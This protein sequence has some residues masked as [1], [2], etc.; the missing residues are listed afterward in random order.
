MPD[1]QTNRSELP[2]ILGIH[3]VC[4]LFRALPQQAAGPILQRV[5][6][7]AA[8]VRM[9]AGSACQPAI[10]HEISWPR[11]SMPAMRSL[12]W[13]I[14]G[15]AGC[16]SVANNKP[17]AGNDGATS[18]APG[19]IHWVRSLS[20]MEALGV[21][22]G[23]GGL[24]VAGAISAPANLGGQTLVPAGAFD[25]IVAGFD[26]ETADHVFSVR[27]GDVGSEF[28]FLHYED[29][30]GAPMVYGVSYGNVDLGLNAMAGGTPSSTAF[31]DGFVGR[32]GPAAP[33]WIARIVRTNGTGSMGEDK[34]L[35]SAPGPG[36]TIYAGGYLTETTTFSVTGG[37]T[38]TLTS[39]GGRDI[40]LARFNTFTGAVDLTKTYGGTAD[41]EITSAASTGGNLVIAGRFG[42]PVAPQ[43]TL[44][45]GGTAAPLTSNGGLDIFVAKLDTSG[46]G[47]WAVHFGGAGDERDPRIA[48]DAAGDVYVTGTFTG[49]IAFGAVNLASMGDVDVFV[50]KLH[51]SDGSVAWAISRGTAGTD[52]AGDIAI[53]AM[54]HVVLGASL[55][56]TP[57][58]NGDALLESFDA[59]NGSS[60]WARMFATS[61]PDGVGVMTSGRNGD[62]Y[63]TVGLGG[64]FDFGMPI[65]GAAGPAAV[66]IRVAP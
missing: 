13:L 4:R 49:Q 23:P 58:A 17:D 29:S 9:I 43:G 66:L 36:S 59:S 5:Q 46:N 42:D 57:S 8:N 65:I 25:M 1:W 45:F 21:A 44:K 19:T 39:T 24:T 10:R 51:G 34:I 55:N 54:G 11:A 15:A 50:A 62:I 52:R 64:T 16:G 18:A 33:A 14:V 28:G 20:S 61:G 35:A 3:D 32:Y 40:F 60:R 31:A 22:D 53:D 27:H 38:A 41:D 47:V 63:A 2:K 56:G 26:A 6:P 7:I 37:T 12:A 48:L 30:N